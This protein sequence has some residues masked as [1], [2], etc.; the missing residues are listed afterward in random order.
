MAISSRSAQ[1]WPLPRFQPS[2]SGCI[3]AIALFFLPLAPLKLFPQHFFH[4]SLIKGMKG[5]WLFLFLQRPQEL[6]LLRLYC[7]KNKIL[8]PRGL[9][10]LQLTRLTLVLHKK[11]KKPQ[12]ASFS[13]K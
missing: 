7:I 11:K 6:I 1:R 4:L 3:A 13:V 12:H 8:P 5:T 2:N 9:K 10:S